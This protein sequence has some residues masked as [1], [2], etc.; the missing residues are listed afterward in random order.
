MQLLEK[1]LKREEKSLS[2]WIRE[3]AAKYVAD[4]KEGNWQLRLDK[5][6]AVTNH[7]TRHPSDCRFWRSRP[8]AQPP[9]Q[10]F[11]S[12]RKIMVLSASCCDLWKAT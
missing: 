3:Y 5:Y 4:H 11:C 8:K 9:Y 12:K 2:E 1:V 10:A 6:S 7:K